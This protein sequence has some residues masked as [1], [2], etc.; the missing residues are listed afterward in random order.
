MELFSTDISE[1]REAGSQDYDPSVLSK[2]TALV[3]KELVPSEIWALESNAE[4]FE[5]T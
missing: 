3:L 4:L 2:F 5:R 1:D